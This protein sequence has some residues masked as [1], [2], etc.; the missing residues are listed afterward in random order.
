MISSHDSTGYISSR[1]CTELI[2]G[3]IK[4]IVFQNSTKLPLSTVLILSQDII[5]IKFIMRLPWINLSWDS[6]GLNLAKYFT[7]LILSENKN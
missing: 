5:E 2:C 1:N 3:L 4:L 7:E 6:T